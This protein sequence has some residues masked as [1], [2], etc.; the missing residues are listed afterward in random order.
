MLRKVQLSS[1]PGSAH[2]GWLS[3]YYVYDDFGNL[4]FVIPP[5]AVDVIKGT[6]TISTSIANELCFQYQ[7]DERKRMIVK[8]VPGAGPVFMVYDVRDRLV[9][10]QD[11]VQ[12]VKLPMEWMVTFYDDINRLVCISRLTMAVL[13]KAF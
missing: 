12:R 7:Y 4:R 1:T 2:I 6:W 13:N 11:S 5:L 8:K 3:T 10:T 9:F